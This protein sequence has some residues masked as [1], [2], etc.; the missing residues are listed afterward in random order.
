VSVTRTSSLMLELLPKERQAVMVIVP[1][2]GPDIVTPGDGS[3]NENVAE[4]PIVA[5]VRL[6]TTPPRRLLFASA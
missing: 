1:E 3:G 2:L 5:V 4:P 6:S